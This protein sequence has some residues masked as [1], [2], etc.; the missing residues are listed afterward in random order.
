MPRN[1][2]TLDRAVRIIVG[3]VLL[4]LAFFG[5]RTPWGYIGLLPLLTG[6][7]G[8]CPLYAVLGISTCPRGEA[9]SPRSA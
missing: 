1:E 8:F 7:F 4:S 5:P 3:L 2:G 6:M 9:G